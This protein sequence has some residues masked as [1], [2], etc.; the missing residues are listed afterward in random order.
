MSSGKSQLFSGSVSSTGPRGG[1]RGKQEGGE[2]GANKAPSQSD[3]DVP[4]LA[5]ERVYPSHCR[6]AG[7]QPPT[8]QG[9]AFGGGLGLSGGAGP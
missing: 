7:T 8:L 2:L 1:R 3:G 4:D 5:A 9:W 6:R